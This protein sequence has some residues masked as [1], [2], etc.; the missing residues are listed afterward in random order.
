[1]DL[2]IT[3]GNR[4]NSDMLVASG[5]AQRAASSQTMTHAQELDP[6]AATELFNTVQFQQQLQESEQQVKQRQLKQQQRR[7]QQ[8]QQK[9]EQGPPAACPSSVLDIS[10]ASAL[11][12]R[13]AATAKRNEAAASIILLAGIPLPGESDKVVVAAAAARDVGGGGS[14]QES[15]TEKEGEDNPPQYSDLEEFE[16][17]MMAVQRAKGEEAGG[18]GHGK[19]EDMGPLRFHDDPKW[20]FVRCAVPWMGQVGITVTNAILL[21]GGR[22]R[23][24][25][26]VSAVGEEGSGYRAGVRAGDCITKVEGRDV[27]GMPCAELMSTLQD[28]LR[29]RKEIDPSM[30]LEFIFARS[31]P[32]QTTY[33]GTTGSVVTVAAAAAD[34]DAVA[35]A[36]S[37]S[38]TLG[39]DIVAQGATTSSS[40][41]LSS[42]GCTDSSSANTAS[43]TPHCDR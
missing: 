27:T 5:G 33:E 17:F 30:T 43:N 7:L 9:E 4:Q 14:D 31:L 12:V 28:L 32:R 18:K 41:S 29:A 19:K 2:A 8:Q 26:S 35:A 6:A 11:L 3:Q 37:D 39:A 20:Y 36:V 10:E 40:S 42:T 24:V 1:V 21:V 16:L 15:G 22:H 13:T 25:L 34:D 23:H 38:A